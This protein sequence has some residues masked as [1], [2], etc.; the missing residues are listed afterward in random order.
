MIDR[1]VRTKCKCGDRKEYKVQVSGDCFHVIAHSALNAV[2]SVHYDIHNLLHL[3][4]Y[5]DVKI[6]DYIIMK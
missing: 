5:L 4:Q 6:G 3:S 1:R 2:C